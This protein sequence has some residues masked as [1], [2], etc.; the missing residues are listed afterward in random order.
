MRYE[1]STLLKL[2]PGFF[3][4]PALLSH[5]T[6][7]CICLLFCFVFFWSL[8]PWR[9]AWWPWSIRD[10]PHVFVLLCNE[11]SQQTHCLMN[12]ARCWGESHPPSKSVPIQ[13]QPCPFLDHFPA[14]FLCV[15]SSFNKLLFLLKPCL[16][17]LCSVFFAAKKQLSSY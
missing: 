7:I 3:Y 10:A 13:S 17:Y 1:A 9:W 16:I 11:V 2:T 15:F 6:D 12:S 8:W 4:P 14:P 5:S